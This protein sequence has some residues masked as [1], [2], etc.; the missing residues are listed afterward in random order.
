M[1][2]MIIR[3]YLVLFLLIAS[4]SSLFWVTKLIAQEEVLDWRVELQQINAEIKE[5]NDEKNR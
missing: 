4:T 5:L 2:L 3:H 1:L